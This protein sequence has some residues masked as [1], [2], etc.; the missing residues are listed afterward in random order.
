MDHSFHFLIAYSVY[1]FLLLLFMLHS[2][3]FNELHMVQSTFVVWCPW[4]FDI[5][6]DSRYLCI[7]CHVTTL[8]AIYM[9]HNSIATQQYISQKI[10]KWKKFLFFFLVYV[11]LGSY[12]PFTDHAINIKYRFWFT[13]QKGNSQSFVNHFAHYGCICHIDAQVQMYIFFQI[14]CFYLFI[15]HCFRSAIFIQICTYE[16]RW[17]AKIW[18]H[19]SISYTV[20]NKVQKMHKN[21]FHSPG[22]DKHQLLQQLHR[23]KYQKTILDRSFH[24]DHLFAV[25][26]GENNFRISSINR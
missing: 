21:D 19:Q 24:V 11:F 15:F 4:L 5:H 2:F 22:D 7:V 14:Y 16:L 13:S 6:P 17:S 20:Q 25:V 23:I 26:V 3:R 8:F 18:L 10:F 12:E 1:A 9:Q